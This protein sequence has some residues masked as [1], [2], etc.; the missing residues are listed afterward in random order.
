MILIKIKIPI[1]IKLSNASEYN[2]ISCS[3]VAHRANRIHM[4]LI[5]SPIN[6]AISVKHKNGAGL[7]WN[8]K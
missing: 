5:D 6:A 7:L 1:Q 4:V 8:L 3:H 2:D